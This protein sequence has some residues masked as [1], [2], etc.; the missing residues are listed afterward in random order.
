MSRVRAA[1]GGLLAAVVLAGPLSACGGESSTLR[2]ATD[3]AGELC[4]VY[5]LAVIAARFNGTPLAVPD[6]AVPVPPD[7]C[8]GVRE[9]A[10]RGI[11]L[12]RCDRRIGQRAGPDDLYLFSD[13][14][15]FGCCWFTA[16]RSREPDAES[17]MAVLA[18][19]AGAGDVCSR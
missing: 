10:R 4:R 9:R 13:Q 14:A 17:L 12:D 1:I 7:G 6:D 3:D 18:Q 19:G 5:R 15:R 11:R 16:A 8:S 2:V